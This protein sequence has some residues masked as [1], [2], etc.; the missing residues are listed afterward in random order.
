[1]NSIMVMTACVLSYRS[2]DTKVISTGS[3]ADVGDNEH[4]EQVDRYQG[5]RNGFG[6]GLAQTQGADERGP[7]GRGVQGV[8]GGLTE[9][10]TT[11]AKA[12]RK[13][14]RA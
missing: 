13:R 5:A 4:K 3:C 9:R 12:A 14:G 8:I 2:V 1:M 11:A 7:D 6:R 10:E